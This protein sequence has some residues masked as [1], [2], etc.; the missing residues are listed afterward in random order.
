MGQ[1]KQ[2]RPV[3]LIVEDEPL[4]LMDAVEVV[5]D[6]GFE[7][8][9]ARNADDAITILER[10]G[11]I[12]MIFTDINMPRS[13][14]GLKLAHAV[15][16]RWPP[17]EIIP[18]GSTTAAGPGHFSSETLYS[19]ADLPCIGSLLELC[20]LLSWRTSKEKCAARVFFAA[21]L[22]AVE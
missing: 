19:R 5:N 3:V 8:I 12:R 14:D 13:M 17:I 20:T 21:R 2:N 15:R 4:T 1:Q 16:S 11:D 18:W 10:R 22:S 6:A 7:A 9:S